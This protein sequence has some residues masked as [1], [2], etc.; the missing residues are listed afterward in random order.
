MNNLRL[1]IRRSSCQ[2]RQFHKC[3][4]LGQEAVAATTQPKLDFPVPE[5]LDKP[6]SA[7]I[8]KIAQ[9]ITSLNLV[10]VAE[11][12]DLLKRRLNLPDAPMMAVGSVGASKEE[13]DDIPK[14]VK[15]T[16]TVKLMEFEDGKKVNLIKEIKNLMPG[17]NLVQAKKFVE[18]LPAVV[19]PD[20]SKEEADKMKEVIEKAG[21]KVVLE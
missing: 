6:A 17:T 21:G 15:S 14:I 5:G 11:L 18:S 16:F 9:E 7:K 4:P 10:E 13:E 1:I 19:M 20:L 3:I 2:L 8:D 12:S